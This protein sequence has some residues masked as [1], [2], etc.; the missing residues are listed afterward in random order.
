VVSRSHLL[1]EQILADPSSFVPVG[2][3]RSSLDEQTRT[4]G[5]LG[6]VVEPERESRDLSSLSDGLA[7]DRHSRVNFVRA[8]LTYSHSLPSPL[9]QQDVQPSV[10]PNDLDQEETSLLP[11]YQT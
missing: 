2:R 4:F 8:R 10:E 9:F 7:V 3:T 5:S 6:I 1:E 11:R